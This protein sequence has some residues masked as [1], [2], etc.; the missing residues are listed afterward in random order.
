[1]QSRTCNCGEPHASPVKKRRGNSFIEKGKLGEAVINKK[2]T[3]GNR[4]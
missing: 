4:V 2:S 3:G 1:M